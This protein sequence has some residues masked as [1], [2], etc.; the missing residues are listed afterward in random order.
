MVGHN[1]QIKLNEVLNAILS[2]NKI[3]H[4]MQRNYQ[5]QILEHWGVFQNK[6]NIGMHCC[7]PLVSALGGQ[8]HANIYEFKARQAWSIYWI[9]V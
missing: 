9:A 3:I 4:K 8:R 1:L 7:M 2:L 6:K 5:F